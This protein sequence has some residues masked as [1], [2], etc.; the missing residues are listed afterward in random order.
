MKHTI[1]IYQFPTCTIIDSFT[2]QSQAIADKALKALK[3][4]YK[5]DQYAIRHNGN[6]E[7]KG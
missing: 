1:H 5:A 4:Q 6:L 7:Y 2:T 3:Q